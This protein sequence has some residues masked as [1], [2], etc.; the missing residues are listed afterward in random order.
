MK[1]TKPITYARAFSA[2]PA[3]IAELALS[4]L[5]ACGWHSPDEVVAIEA[6][7]TFNEYRLPLDKLALIQALSGFHHHFSEMGAD[8][9]QGV[10]D[11]LEQ[12][13]ITTTP[14]GSIL[15]DADKSKFTAAELALAAAET[16]QPELVGEVKQPRLVAAV[17][18]QKQRYRPTAA[19]HRQHATDI[20]TMLRGGNLKNAIKLL[21]RK[22]KV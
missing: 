21:N 3:D 16:K 11:C 4:E 9:W 5:K 17:A 1:K 18:M 2:L 22:L 13:L 20:A 14:F 6:E 15:P 7:F 10:R 8:Y 19:A 12:H